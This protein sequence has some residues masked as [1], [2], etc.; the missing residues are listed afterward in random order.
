MAAWRGVPQEAGNLD[1]WWSGQVAR[2]G[3]VRSPL[4]NDLSHYSACKGRG[5]EGS[6]LQRKPYGVRGP[7]CS[8]VELPPGCYGGT[9]HHR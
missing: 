5:V 7:G 9:P 3:R 1:G 4:E 2:W 8:M 6:G